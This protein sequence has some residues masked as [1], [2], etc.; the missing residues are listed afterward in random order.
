MS[1]RRLL[2]LLALVPSLALAPAAHADGRPPDAAGSV[3]T[4]RVPEAPVYGTPAGHFVV[5]YVAD[6]AD[7]DAP[8]PASTRVAGVPDWVVEVGDAAEAAWTR[9]TALGF[10]PPPADD[11]DGAERGGDGRYDVYVC[12]L[13]SHDLGE[14]AATVADP[15]G[16]GLSY[17]CLLYTSDAAD[18]EDSVDLGGRR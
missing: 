15:P 3:C 4:Y 1:R 12:D 6:P 11:G 17:I 10:P 16:S 7:P 18:E 13:A 9:E 5:H 14:L 2:A 8:S